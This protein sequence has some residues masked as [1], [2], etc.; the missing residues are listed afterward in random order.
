MNLSEHFTLEEATHS[1]KAIELGID[2]TV[3][4]KE[5]L[6]AAIRT[7]TKMEKV[8]TVLG[9]VAIHVNSF[10]RVPALNAALSNSSRTSQHMKGEAVDFVAP[11][12][13]TPLDICKAIIAAKD[14]IRYDQLI[15]E[16]TWVHISFC[17]P[18]SQ[19]RSE[20]LSLLEGDRK[21][22]PGLTDIKGNKL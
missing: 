16:H 10:I 13:G 21:Y 2:N 4:S 1:A 11:D 8:R 9:N 7:A 18:S 15:H 20:V 3:I 14:L 19:P 12:F 17:S 22:T 6:E 5:I